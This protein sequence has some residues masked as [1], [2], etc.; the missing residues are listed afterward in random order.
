MPKNCVGSEGSLKD[1]KE[2]E[3]IVQHVRSIPVVEKDR[4]VMVWEGR[5][6]RRP[7]RAQLFELQPILGLIS[8]FSQGTNKIWAWLS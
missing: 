7:G 5:T 8:E 2:G 1:P 4:T 3:G 6:K